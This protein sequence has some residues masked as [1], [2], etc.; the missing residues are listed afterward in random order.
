[1]RREFALP[2][3]D[4]QY[5]TTSGFIWETIKENGNWVLIHSYPVPDG[6]NVKEVSVALR[7]DPGYPS[8][9]IDMAYFYPQ[10]QRMDGKVIGALSAQVLLGNQ[11][12]RWS[13]HRTGLNPWRPGVD[14]ICTHLALVSHWLEREFQLR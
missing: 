3:E 6:Y 11:W 14:D 1:M 13:R 4:T 5:L 9:Q 2:E 10:L 7:V 8:S 12:Q